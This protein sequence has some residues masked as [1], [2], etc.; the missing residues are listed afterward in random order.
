MAMDDAMRGLDLTQVMNFFK[1][2]EDWTVAVMGKEMARSV[3]DFVNRPLKIVEFKDGRMTSHK[4]E[5]DA[6]S[7]DMFIS[8]GAFERL[9]PSEVREVHRTVKP[10]A[11][12]LFIEEMMPKEDFEER[13]RERLS[14]FPKH[15]TLSLSQHLCLVLKK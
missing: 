6:N 13:N 8:K 4:G 7:L 10:G 1:I 12:A 2:E 14:I 9:T 11:V 15:L 3:K 5:I